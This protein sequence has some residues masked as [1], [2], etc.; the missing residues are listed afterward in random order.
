MTG[1]AYE[2][3]LQVTEAQEMPLLWATVVVEDSEKRHDQN[4]VY[5]ALVAEE[6]QGGCLQ[7]SSTYPDGI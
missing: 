2:D 7:A 4:T 1:K 3:S 6:R 5:K